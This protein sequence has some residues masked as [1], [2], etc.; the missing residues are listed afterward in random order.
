MGMMP[1]ESH[2]PWPSPLETLQKRYYSP[3]VFACAK[4][5]AKR[6]YRLFIGKNSLYSP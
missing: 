2:I 4:L 6:L 5:R 3:P 1:V